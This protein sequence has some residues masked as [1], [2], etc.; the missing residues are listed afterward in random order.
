IGLSAY[1]HSCAVLSDGRLNCWGG[2]FSGQL[3]VP[4][5]DLSVTNVPVEAQGIAN[6][7]GVYTGENITCVLMATGKV[8]C[9][10]ARFVFSE[11][12]VEV[13]NVSNAVGMSIGYYNA[14]FLLDEG[15][16]K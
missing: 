16:V 13:Q 11:T 15:Y 10:G 12:P 6:A 7:V 4:S 2:N 8:N 5:E 3:S 1:K 14:C 9:I